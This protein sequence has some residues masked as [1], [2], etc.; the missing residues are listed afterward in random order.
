MI[1][2]IEISDLDEMSSFI[3]TYRCKSSGVAD[4]IELIQLAKDRNESIK[5][6]SL[7]DQ[8]QI[9]AISLF[10]FSER[11]VSLVNYKSMHLYGFNFYDYNTLN[12]EEKYESQFL[13]FIKRYAKRNHAQLIILE[14][15]IRKFKCKKNSEKIQLFDSLKSDNGF[16]YIINKK[17]L[18]GYKNKLEELFEYTVSHYT[19]IEITKELIDELAELHKERWGFDN[20]KSAFQDEKR[21]Q[22]YLTHREN[23]VL[24]IISTNNSILAVHYGMIY[25]NCLLFHTPV[26]NIEYY[27]YSPFVNFIEILIL[28]TALYCK[29]NQIDIL[30]FGLGDE[31]YKN[32]YTNDHKDIFTYYLTIGM[33]STIKFRVSTFI[34]KLGVKNLLNFIRKIYHKIQMM[35]N[36]INVYEFL[37]HPNNKEESKYFHYIENYSDFVSLYRRLKYPVKRYHYNRFRKGDLFYCLLEDNHLYCSGWSTSKDMY[38]SEIDKTLKADG[39]VILYDYHTPE[40]F[41]RKGKYQELLE[42]IISYL[43]SDVFI[44]AL[45][46]NIASN[47]AIQKVG[48]QK[49][50][51][52]QLR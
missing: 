33:I 36:K 48:F 20:I 37:L 50:K 5:L 39:K 34:K 35:T 40:E 14:N 45:T 27:K 31:T 51:K 17:R 26:I 10:Q 52:D 18:K 19:G 41:R 47:R 29:E 49:I 24:T 25:N 12:I 2:E 44:Y 23:K 11:R 22:D 1:E 7:K 16:D 15:V 21:K 4:F 43:N 38:V 46:N 8:D 30:D 28:E 13:R 42:S 32:K 6:L 9:V 3:S